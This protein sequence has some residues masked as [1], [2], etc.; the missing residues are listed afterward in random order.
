MCVCVRA[1]KSKCL[2]YCNCAGGE[3]KKD[4]AETPRCSEAAEVAR[5]A[6]IATV[7]PG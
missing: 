5:P 6:Q 2:L 3:E 7:A 4:R 1:S